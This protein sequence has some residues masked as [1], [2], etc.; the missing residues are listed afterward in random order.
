METENRICPKECGVLPD[1]I[2]HVGDVSFP[3]HKFLL[4]FNSKFL[5][6]AIEAE[7][8]MKELN[9]PEDIDKDTLCFF[10][11]LIHDRDLAFKPFPNIK[12]FL[13]F[14]HLCNFLDSPTFSLSEYTSDYNLKDITPDIDSKDLIFYFQEADKLHLLEFEEKLIS[15]CVNDSRFA[16]N[17]FKNFH[18]FPERVKEEISKRLLMNK[19]PHLDKWKKGQ[20]IMFLPESDRKWDQ[21]ELS[22]IDK[23]KKFHIISHNYYLTMTRDQIMKRI[24]YGLM[25]FGEN[26]HKDIPKNVFELFKNLDN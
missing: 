18:N 1:I 22:L 25:Y 8:D 24:E 19:H 7:K 5:K 4:M 20:K 16:T 3:T 23:E 9:L 12:K 15:V 26:Q 10:L 14:V 6:I 17:I 21:G 2:L 13:K 11:Q